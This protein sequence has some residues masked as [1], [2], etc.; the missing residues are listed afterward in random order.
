MVS[1]NRLTEKHYGGKGYYML[2]SGVLRCD[3]KCGD[4]DELDKLVDR[5]GEFEDKAE[6]T[7]EVV[8]CRD[9]KHLELSNDGEHNPNDCVCHYWMS[10]GLTDN[11][12]CLFG[13][14]RDNGT[15]RSMAGDFRK[16]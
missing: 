3:G 9:C 8:R 2:C 4:C 7:V 1:E 13:E 14:R 16:P 11:D 5:L 15:T 10:D 6:N 12:Y